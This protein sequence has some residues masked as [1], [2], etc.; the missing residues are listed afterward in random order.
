MWKAFSLSF[1]LSANGYAALSKTYPT[2]NT[3]TL[4]MDT[5]QDA[6]Q[7]IWDSSVPA[8]INIS[9]TAWEFEKAVIINKIMDDDMEQYLVWP[10]T[11]VAHMYLLDGKTVD[12]LKF[13]PVDARTG[14]AGWRGWCFS[15]IN[16]HEV[17]VVCPE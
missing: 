17:P 10:G 7:T 16:N 11:D 9:T 2:A 13:P 4:R 6:I 5:Y 3:T 14:I 15:I 8:G 12:P 1:L